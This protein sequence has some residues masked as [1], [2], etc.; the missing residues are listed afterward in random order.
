M[1]DLIDLG[2]MSSEPCDRKTTR[3]FTTKPM[4]MVWPCPSCGFDQKLTLGGIPFTVT[5]AEHADP[6]A[7]A[8]VPSTKTAAA[9]V[10]P[11]SKA[12]TV[13]IRQPYICPSKLKPED[14][15]PPMGPVLDEQ[16]IPHYPELF[17]RRTKLWTCP[18]CCRGRS[19][20]EAA[21]WAHMD[22]RLDDGI[23]FACPI[24]KCYE[25]A[26]ND[27]NNAVPKTGGKKRSRS[28]APEVL[29]M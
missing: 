27:Y 3:H 4:G 8:A 10:V 17:N 28:V 22:S 9:A 7:S 29:S 14:P 16:G 25:N 23:T 11:S 21:M 18:G 26:C 19:A 15:D 24:G 20:G 5:P 13:V 6:A 1:I 12:V 2:A